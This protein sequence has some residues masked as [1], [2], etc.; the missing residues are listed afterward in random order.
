MP[1]ND[2]VERDEQVLV[3]EEVADDGGRDQHP[4]SGDKG[5]IHT[6]A[7]T[8]SAERCDER[9]RR[10]GKAVLLQAPSRCPFAPSAGVTPKN[11]SR[12]TLFASALPIMISRKVLKSIVYASFFSAQAEMIASAVPPRAAVLFLLTALTTA[13]TIASTMKPPAGLVSRGDAVRLEEVKRD[14]GKAAR[15]EDLSYRG[16]DKERRDEAETRE[17]AVLRAAPTLCCAARSDSEKI[18]AS[19]AR[20]AA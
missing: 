18:S 10:D 15:A 2:A 1:K 11:C 14:P 7:D 9:D 6:D 17:E 4:E 19:T 3:G 5:R 12:T 13:M 8:G 20:S 16:G